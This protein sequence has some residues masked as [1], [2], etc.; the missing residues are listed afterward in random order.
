MLASALVI[1]VALFF[2][3]M[4]VYALVRPERVVAIFGTPGLTVDGRNEIR[5]VYGGFGVAV[6]AVL[7]VSL[8]A[9]AWGAG[10]VLAIALALLGMAGGRLVS[11]AVDRGLGG[12]PALF[13]VIELALGGS[14]LWVF[15]KQ[16]GG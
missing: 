4:G 12:Y 16:V 15:S 5:A 1:G 14:L 10:V 8:R 9:P 7:W 2:A 3:L 6:A 11:L 13:G